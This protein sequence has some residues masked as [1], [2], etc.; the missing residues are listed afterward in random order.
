MGEE[1]M[2]KKLATAVRSIQW[3]YA[4]FWSPS[5]QHSGVLEWG[6]GYYNGGIKTRKTIQSMDIK[7]DD[8]TI[9]QRSDQLRE[10][11]LSLLSGNNNNNSSINNNENRRPLAALSP[12][13]LTDVEWFYLVCMSFVFNIAQGLPGSSLENGRTIWLANAHC[14]DTRV[15]TRSLLAKSAGVQT[16][17]CFPYQTGVIEFGVTDLVKED[18]SLIQHI[19]ASLDKSPPPPQPSFPPH[20]QGQDVEL[21]STRG[22]SIGGVELPQSLDHLYMFEGHSVFED[23]NVVNPEIYTSTLK[24]EYDLNFQNKNGIE[25]CDKISEDS[26]FQNVL[27]SLFKKPNHGFLQQEKLDKKP[28]FIRWE[29]GINIE[30]VELSVVVPQCMLKKILFQ[31]PLM[32]SAHSMRCTEDRTRKDELCK[33]EVPNMNHVLAERRRREKVNER[34]SILRSL[35]PTRSK[36]DKISILDDTITYL[37]ELERR[38]ED[39]KSCQV[40]S[41]FD[42]KKKRKTIEI[43]EETSDNYGDDDINAGAIKNKGKGGTMRREE[44]ECDQISTKDNSVDKII[45]ITN[46]IVDKDTLINI[47]CPWRE[48][49]L[50]QIIDAMSNLHLDSQSIHSSTI[51]GVLSL[52]IQ[53]KV[54][55]S[56]SVSAEA[57]TQTLLKIIRSI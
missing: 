48:S 30:K 27:S 1:N 47:S 11:Y 5:P 43:D 37:K 21:L 46:S 12:E 7:A 49:L 55:G 15:F 28:S 32:H 3:S 50:L 8:Q 51:D 44:Q 41:S 53:S 34:F 10:L 23:Y 25:K 33:Q 20:V 26:H 19:R 22:S 54:K 4:I 45:T 57:I 35:I 56:T 18:I 6:D 52:E 29:K 14:V 39:L 13:D 40:L 36:A 38:V 24:P 17:L 42:V 16:V 2:K 31:V 9:S